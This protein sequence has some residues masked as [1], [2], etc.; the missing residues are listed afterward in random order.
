MFLNHTHYVPAVR[1]K[2]AEK[3][4]LQWL[5][6]EERTRMLPLIEIIPRNFRSNDG[7]DRPVR[8]AVRLIARDINTC[9][10]STATFVDLEHIVNAGIRAA[11]DSPHILELL[12]QETR[13][14]LPLFPDDS[15][16]IPVTGL[17]RAGDY[18]SA[19]ASII[20]EDRT[21][22]CVR[23]TLADVSSPGFST[24]LE[25][26][27]SRLKLE[28]SDADL[29]VDFRASNGSRPNLQS[30]CA[31]LPQLS[32]WRSFV[33]LAGAFPKDLQGLE[34]NRQH[35]LPRDEWFY[36]REQIL[37]LPRSIRRRT[38]GDYTIQHAIYQ[39]PPENSNP[40]AS[41]RYTHSDYWI[42]MRG[43]GL[44]NENGPGNAP[45]PAEAQLLCERDEF[46]GGGFS[47]GD[48]YMYETSQTP[49][50]PGTPL[51]WLRAGINHHMVYAVRQIA[52][53]FETPA[54]RFVGD[55]SAHQA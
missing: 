1:W 2:Q 14:V 51:T 50:T 16:L 39:E 32:K 47:P 38:F 26:L 33:L 28:V 36:W 13:R 27:L 17:S 9:W 30:L 48:R 34:R 12:A 8:E 41:I 42:I 4:A 45:Y 7:K 6:K 5:G 46:C 37:T 3:E 18:Q 22:V 52:A 53:F 40:S 55:H 54:N 25:T 24:K 35:T 21:G 20:E 44:K 49:G 15:K 11:N 43:E 19:V 29:V 10:G 31:A 23:V